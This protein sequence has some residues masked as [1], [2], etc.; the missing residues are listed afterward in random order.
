LTPRLTT[1]LFDLDGTLVNLERRGLELRFML[2]AFRR[3]YP[4]IRP[5]RFRRAFWLAAERLQ[6]HGTGQTN[7]QVFLE[8]LGAQSRIDLHATRSGRGFSPAVSPISS[9]I[10]SR[11]AR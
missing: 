5:W 10:S 4:A 3:F 9:S 11:T 6:V 2:R 8:T 7:Y 1:L